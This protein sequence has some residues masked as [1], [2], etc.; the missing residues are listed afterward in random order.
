MQGG[1]ARRRRTRVAILSVQLLLVD[2]DDLVPIRADDPHLDQRDGRSQRDEVQVDPTG[3][4]ISLELARCDLV[5][6][7]A[8]VRNQREGFA[9]RCDRVAH[10]FGAEQHTA[11]AWRAPT[12]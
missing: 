2:G 7:R 3:L 8:S 10:L 5:P 11:S 1:A 6:S 12:R 9:G 4:I